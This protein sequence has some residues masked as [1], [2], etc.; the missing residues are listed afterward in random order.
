[1]QIARVIVAGLTMLVG[2]GISHAQQS[3][4]PAPPEQLGKVY[5]PTSCS[6]AVTKQFDRAL[7][8]RYFLL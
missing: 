4:A 5:F 3:H 8:L 1:M 7:A 6:R 2:V